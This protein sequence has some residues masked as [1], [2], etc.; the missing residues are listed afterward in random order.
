MS[1]TICNLVLLICQNVH[2]TVQFLCFVTWLLIFCDSHSCTISPYTVH[3]LVLWRLRLFST[4]TKT[5]WKVL[6]VIDG[7][8]M[9]V[10]LLD[11]NME[12]HWLLLLCQWL[13]FCWRYLN[14]RYLNIIVGSVYL[15]DRCLSPSLVV[16]RFYSLHIQN[17]KKIIMRWKSLTDSCWWDL[18]MFGFFMIILF[19]ILIVIL[20]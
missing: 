13:N 19:N 3:T 6:F 7:H 17:I 20:K 1:W 4:H 16:S 2:F 18:V 10:M 11:H 9:I 14:D 5:S 8:P 15:N 12:D